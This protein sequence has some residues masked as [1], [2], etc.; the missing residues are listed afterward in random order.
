V[1]AVK[2]AI[3]KTILYQVFAGLKAK[4]LLGHAPPH[5]IE[6]ACVL[7]FLS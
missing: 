6:L 4:R 3:K 5:R 1:H 2:K 7:K